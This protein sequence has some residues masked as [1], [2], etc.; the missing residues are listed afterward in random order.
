MKNLT[1]YFQSLELVKAGVPAESSDY[2]F[3]QDKTLDKDK[4]S[5]RF[6]Y[7]PCWSIGAL[8]QYLYD[9]NCDVAFSYDTEQTL[10]ELI[11]GLVNAAC[12]ARKREDE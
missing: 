8:W 11:Q 4:I 10:D 9:H 1:D 3:H 12:I 6:P 2:F 5:P 7:V